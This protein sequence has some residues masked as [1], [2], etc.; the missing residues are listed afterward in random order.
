MNYDDLVQRLRDSAGI[1]AQG[2]RV[3]GYGPAG[4]MSEFKKEWTLY[5]K[6]ADAIQ[7]LQRDAGRYRFIR[8]QNG[9]P[10]PGEFDRLV[11]DDMS[12]EVAA[13]DKAMESQV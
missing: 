13:I 6:A 1:E 5:W 9:A 2:M 7:S 11:D 4:G 8:N 12:S 10:T 3:A